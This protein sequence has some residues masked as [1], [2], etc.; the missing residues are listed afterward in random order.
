MKRPIALVF[1]IVALLIGGI[2]GYSLYNKG[3]ESLETQPADVTLSPEALFEAYNTD[4]SSADATYLNKVIEVSG[5]LSAEPQIV[6][7]SAVLVIAVADEPFGISC[8]LS[9]T[10]LDK[11]Q[12][13][14]VGAPLT[15]RGV[16]TGF[17]MDV[18]LVRCV[19]I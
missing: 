7:S 5:P 18:N 3:F 6:D 15:I 9:A 19:I 14:K 16:C 1:V 4:E 13:L 17:L 12:N 11:V 8:S 2:T 10:E